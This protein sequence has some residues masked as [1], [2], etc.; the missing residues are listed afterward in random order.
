MGAKLFVDEFEET[1]MERATCFTG[2][3]YSIYDQLALQSRDLTTMWTL[4]SL[5]RCARLP[6][7]LQ[8]RWHM[9]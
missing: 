4:L 6:K 7:R 5:V 8:T 9:Q 1:F 2:D 3:L